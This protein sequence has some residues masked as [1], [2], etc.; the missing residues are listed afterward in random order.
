MAQCYIIGC[1]NGR[2][3][4]TAL[5]TLP[6]VSN[7]VKKINLFRNPKEVEYLKLWEKSIP[8]ETGISFPK[9]YW[10][11]EEHFEE[12][13]II[14]NDITVINGQQVL[15]PRQRCKLKDGV[16]PKIFIGTP[17]ELLPTTNSIRIQETIRLPVSNVKYTTYYN[18]CSTKTKK[19]TTVTYSH[20]AN[21]CE[22]ESHIET[23]NSANTIQ[24]EEPIEAQS[25]TTPEEMP[26]QT[27]SLPLAYME[28]K[29]PS[30]MWLKKQVNAYSVNYFEV[31]QKDFSLAIFKNV[32]INWVSDIHKVTVAVHSK[33]VPDFD[34]A[35]MPCTTERDIE[36]LLISI[37]K[38][39]LCPGIK[40]DENKHPNHTKVVHNGKLLNNVW[41]ANS[42]RILLSATEKSTKPCSACKLLDHS[43]RMQVKRSKI[44]KE[45]S[46]QNHRYMHLKQLAKK[47]REEGKKALY[48]KRQVEKKNIEIKELKLQINALRNEIAS[49]KKDKLKAVLDELDD[50]V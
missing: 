11:C 6:N 34:G 16:L 39:R 9:N 35:S 19:S 23:A 7:L 18:R 26:L 10:L 29:L 36:E 30:S 42:C 2:K 48:F 37:D 8:K 1:R 13:D 41:L 44:M 5:G 38:S 27:P 21:D 28:V 31:Q 32:N 17:T 50:K 22:Q 14:R 47:V 4:R 33:T 45:N 15:L 25:C 3:K 24:L 12:G 43:M 49:L 20:S 46:K 40:N